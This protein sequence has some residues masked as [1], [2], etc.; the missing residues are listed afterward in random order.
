MFRELSVLAVCSH[1]HPPPHPTQILEKLSAQSVLSD[2]CRAGPVSLESGPTFASF[3]EFAVQLTAAL[4]SL[5]THTLTRA[6]SA[7][8]H[9][10]AM[11]HGDVAHTLRREAVANAASIT[12]DPKELLVVIAQYLN[13]V[14]MRK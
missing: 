14:G 6:G 2:V 4:S 7:L 10:T 3:Q 12:Y 5:S 11:A 9:Q 1:P 8:P 13:A